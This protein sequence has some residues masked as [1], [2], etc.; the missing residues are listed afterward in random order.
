MGR[1]ASSQLPRDQGTVVRRRTGRECK[2]GV[3]NRQLN[4][5]GVLGGGGE[6][7]VLGKRNV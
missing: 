6:M 4:R 7:G 1:P 3:G 5:A 2:E